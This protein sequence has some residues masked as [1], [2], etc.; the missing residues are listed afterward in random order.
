MKLEHY[1]EKKLAGELR[2]IVSKYVDDDAR[3]F[4]F[5]SRVSGG[6]SERSDIDF[7]IDAGCPVNPKDFLALREEIDRLPVL[8]TID[9]VDF[10]RVSPIFKKVAMKTIQEI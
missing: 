1:S 8:Y 2:A 5:G 3:M 4:F 9:V 10:S 7:G 6:A